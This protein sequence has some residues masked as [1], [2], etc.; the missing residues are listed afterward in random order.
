MYTVKFSFEDEAYEPVTIS[1]IPAGYSLLEVALDAEIKLHHNCGMVCSCS[2]CHVYV[3][4]GGEFLDA[5]SEREIGF[6]EQA[7][8]ARPE[9]RLGCQSVLLEGDGMIEVIVPDQALL[10]RK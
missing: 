1:K 4:S 10:D 9:S 7:N 5:P 3:A 8:N 2:T 6:L